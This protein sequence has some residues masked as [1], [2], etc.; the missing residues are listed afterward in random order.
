MPGRRD[1]AED[2]TDAS[3]AIRLQSPKCNSKFQHFEHFLATSRMLALE[4]HQACDQFAIDNAL[5]HL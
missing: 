3:I 5:Q 1:L 4:V 2:W